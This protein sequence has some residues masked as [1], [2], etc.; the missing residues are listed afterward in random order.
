MPSVR[1]ASPRRWPWVLLFGALAALA[2]F[3]AWDARGYGPRSL[4]REAEELA[5]VRAG[6]T[7]DLGGGPALSLGESAG[8]ST[9]RER[10]SA[11]Q[12]PVP[13][14][15]AWVEVTVIARPHG[16]P[17]ANASI[18]LVGLGLDWATTDE[19]GRAR[20]RVRAGSTLVGVDLG[21]RRDLI[22]QE[23]HEGGVDLAEVDLML[24]E[25]ETH[26][27]TLYVDRPA[28]LSGKILP[29]MEAG[30]TASEEAGSEAKLLV[31]VPSSATQGEARSTFC[32]E[33]QT[34][35]FDGLYP[36]DYT[37]HGGS[38]WDAIESIAV[39]N[40]LPGEGREVELKR[41]PKR[42]IQLEFT[43]LCGE[44]EQPWPL[45]SAWTLKALRPQELR[46]E[47]EIVRVGS[48]RRSPAT[49]RVTLDL[50]LGDYVLEAES[51]GVQNAWRPFIWVAPRWERTR[52]LQVTANTVE[53]KL[54]FRVPEVG[55]VAWV[56]GQFTR[57][58][59]YDAASASV[60]IRYAGAGGRPQVE[61]LAFRRGA[62]RFTV[63]VDLNL[64]PKRALELY[65]GRSAEA[66]KPWGV[67]SL[68]PGSLAWLVTPPGQ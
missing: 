17:L 61:S 12:E 10:A 14:G 45:P 57:P 52:A 41:I 30:D 8:D 67:V 29:E 68:A 46:E 66:G 15:M 24:V 23:L 18:Y 43:R 4:D 3:V 21:E 60:E 53:V 32:D 25:G 16:V 36:G 11:S 64:V 39:V 50:P 28:W 58:V 26:P 2:A 31:L 47:P 54:D 19:E 51:M 48:Y 1:H 63:A 9:D 59:G 37:L 7:P 42:S 6:R 20:A 34:F 35:R 55:E 49:T 40:L 62:S 33:D 27:V 44:T 56:E 65:P 38:S 5:V 22:A 13:G